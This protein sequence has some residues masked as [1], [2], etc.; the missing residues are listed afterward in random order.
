MKLKKLILIIG[1]IF[2]LCIA[3]GITANATTYNGTCGEN[4]TWELN[5][6]T[7]KL[8]ISGSGDMYQ[9][10]TNTF[11]APWYSY[12]SSID[13]VVVEN[14]VTNINSCAF[15]ACSFLDIIV[16]PDSV[17]RIG[18]YAFYCCTYLENIYYNGSE[19]EWAAISIDENANECLDSATIH[20]ISNEDILEVTSPTNARIVDNEITATVANRIDTLSVSVWVINGTTWE[21]YR[22]ESA[23]KPLDNNT[24]TGLR[25]GKDNVYYIKTLS[26]DGTATKTYKLTIYRNTKSTTPTISANRDMVTISAENCEIYYTIDGTTPT[27]KSL[28]YTEPFSAPS[29]SVIKAIAKENGKDEVS[30]IIEY[31]VPEYITTNIETIYVDKI[32]NACEYSFYVTSDGTPSGIFLVAI[33]NDKGQLI[34]TKLKPITIDGEQEIADSVDVNGTPHTYKVFFWNSLNTLTPMCESIDS[35]I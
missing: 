16:I 34:G 32:T 12:R 21:L 1:I 35:E 7:R 3:F 11:R 27:V 22:T 13:T 17:T 6:S 2:T 19:S 8:T 10:Y 9:Y 18:Y 15:Y 23:T 26:A 31:T 29:N 24:A 14:G 4:V 20:Y 25:E 5:T 28:K 33:Y 30:N